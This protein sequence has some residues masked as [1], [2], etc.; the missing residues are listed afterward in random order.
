MN[1]FRPRRVRI[2]EPG[3]EGYNGFLGMTPF[4]EGLS[5]DLVPFHQQQILGSIVRIESADDG[6][7]SRQ[8]GP[9]AEL[10]R[11]R[12]IAFDHE[13]VAATDQG[14]PVGDHGEM[15]LAVE[16][17]T[18]GELEDIADRRGIAGLREI[19][20]AYV[21]KGRA[22]G[23]LIDAILE[24]QVKTDTIPAPIAPK[25]ANPETPE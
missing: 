16:R 7:E 11:S 21:V 23:E 3:W 10:V 2:V 18:R 25:P 1:P 9:S 17:Y 15:R 8:L 12:D 6:E 14:V 24:A 5:V 13:R 22:I 19:G 4:A 20:D